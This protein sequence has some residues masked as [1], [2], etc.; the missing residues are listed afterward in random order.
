[1][2]GDPSKTQFIKGFHASGHLSQSDLVRVIDDIDPDKI[3]PIHTQHPDWFT[4]IFP[5]NLVGGCPCGFSFKTPHG[6]DDA[7]AVL[8]NHIERIHP[9]DYPKGLTRKEALEHI[10]SA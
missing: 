10:K 8:Q 3:I 9:K 7:V 2:V 5:K 1:M 6:E 4:T